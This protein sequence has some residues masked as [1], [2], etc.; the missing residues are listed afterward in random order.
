MK[1]NKQ[2]FAQEIKNVLEELRT[3]EHGLSEA[4]AKERLTVDG[5]NE[6]PEVKRDSSMAIFWRQFKSPLIYVLLLAGIVVVWRKEF[7]DALVIFFV[8]LFNAVVGAIQEGKAQNTFLA[9]K[10]FIK[11]SAI[12]LR[13]GVEVIVSDRDI[14]LG[15]IIIIREGEKI[16]AEGHAA[17]HNQHGGEQADSGG[18]RAAQALPAFPRI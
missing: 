2:Y 4:E 10:K 16:P 14:V 8:L 3:S 12:I 15:D 7:A 17:S 11:G 9:L 18:G 5:F 6:L 1:D 13:D